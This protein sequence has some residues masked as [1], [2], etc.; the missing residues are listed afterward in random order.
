MEGRVPKT[1]AQAVLG[2]EIDIGCD[3]AQASGAMIGPLYYRETRG[4][5]IAMEAGFARGLAGWTVSGPA[6]LETAKAAEGEA[7]LHIV[8]RPPR[9][10]YLHS[11]PFR[12]TPG[13]R[14]T[15]GGTVRMTPEPLDL[16]FLV[17]IFL[18]A[19]NKEV[20]RARIALRPAFAVIASA[21]TS[22]DGGFALPLPAG[23]DTRDIR[24]RVIYPGDARF[25]GAMLEV[26]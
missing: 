20:S 24:L 21:R 11:A 10:T 26:R 5:G 4:G 16:G 12:V 15:F 19:Q 23:A 2:A 14:F 25:R 13:A 18:D 6:S 17:A 3:C 1:A 7:F 8:A 22:A 9:G